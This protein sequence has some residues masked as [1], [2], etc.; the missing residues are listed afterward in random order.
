MFLNLK[1]WLLRDTCNKQK[2]GGS[3]YPRRPE[4]E[5]SEKA[6]FTTADNG[7]RRLAIET[8]QAGVEQF[9]RAHQLHL[10]YR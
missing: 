5:V 8:M 2:V 4:A 3:D 6:L 7:Q 10:V 1:Y 9:Y